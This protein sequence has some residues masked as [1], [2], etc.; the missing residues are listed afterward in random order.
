M[1]ETRRGLPRLL[2]QRTAVRLL[3]RE[4]WALSRGGKHAVKMRREGR[5]PITLPHAH[6][7]TYSRG[8]TLAIYREAGL[9]PEEGEV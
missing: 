8:L 2:S 9:L 5:R 1:N 4:G 7:E 3:A 6:G